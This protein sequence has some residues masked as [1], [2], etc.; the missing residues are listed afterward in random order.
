MSE[1]KQMCT[2]KNHY[3]TVIGGKISVIFYVRNAR[4]CCVSVNFSYFR[5]LTLFVCRA[6]FYT[7]VF[8]DFKNLL[9]S[10]RVFFYTV[11]FVW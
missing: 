3:V 5:C 6:N 1:N 7:V 4:Q 8:Y 10:S 11:S 2:S 9:T